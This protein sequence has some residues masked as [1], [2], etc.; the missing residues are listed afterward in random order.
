VEV[1]RGTP[2]NALPTGTTTYPGSAKSLADGQPHADDTWV[3]TAV[4]DTASWW[5]HT[6]VLLEGPAPDKPEGAWQWLADLVA[7]DPTV[8]GRQP[9]FG[10]TDLAL[11]NSSFGQNLRGKVRVREDEAARTKWYELGKY[12]IATFRVS[13]ANGLAAQ[14]KITRDLGANIPYRLFGHGRVFGPADAESCSSW[15]AAVLQAAGISAG[16]WVFDTPAGVA[17]GT[18]L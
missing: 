1:Q 8:E 2:G 5:G 15:V 4:A 6:W 17:G 9:R 18:G 7:E 13:A 16:G 10:I 14:A 3:I 12:R 11:A